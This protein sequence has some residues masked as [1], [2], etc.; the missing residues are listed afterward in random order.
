MEKR[1]AIYGSDAHNW[2]SS[3]LNIKRPSEI[4]YKEFCVF[5]FCFTRRTTKIGVIGA[6]KYNGRRL[7]TGFL[8][9]LFGLRSIKSER[10]IKIEIES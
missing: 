2:Q 4:C 7:L 10:R 1:M 3:Y 6:A 8:Y 9:H 5:A